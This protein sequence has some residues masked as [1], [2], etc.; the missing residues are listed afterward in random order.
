MNEIVALWV[1]ASAGVAVYA[2]LTLPTWLFASM[3]R[4][5]LWRLRDR[6][7]D[8]RLH[9]LVP[10][11]PEV[12]AFIKRL[13]AFVVVLPRLGALQVGWLNK[14]HSGSAGEAVPK[15]SQSAAFRDDATALQRI[16]VLEDELGRIVLRQYFIGSWSGLLLV[17]P[18]HSRDVR[19]VLRRRR[20]GEA[21]EASGAPWRTNG[22]VA[23]IENAVSVLSR[24]RPDQDLIAAAG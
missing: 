22:V 19:A 24:R 16:A 11:T 13:E 14:H 15:L 20:N 8:A 3:N 5:A 1:C 4:S 6:A 17:A 23:E 2:A 10:D 21:V 12:D 9:G 18:R 7:F